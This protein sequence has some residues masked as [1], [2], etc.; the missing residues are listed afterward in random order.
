[1]QYTSKQDTV[2]FL[3]QRNPHSLPEQVHNTLQRLIHDILRRYK[4]EQKGSIQ[5]ESAP[6]LTVVA[7]GCQSSHSYVGY[8]FFMKQILFTVLLL[9]NGSDKQCTSNSSHFLSVPSISYMVLHIPLTHIE[10]RHFPSQTVKA[11]I[12]RWHAN[13]S[14]D[15]NVCKYNYKW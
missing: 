1:M 9:F 15:P 13:Q 3:F 6:R 8:V 10:S 14:S 2:I 11:L 7:H 4:H 12:K 5:H